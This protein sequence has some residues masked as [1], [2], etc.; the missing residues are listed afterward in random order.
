MRYLKWSFWP[1]I[2]SLFHGDVFILKS[3]AMWE[4]LVWLSL[5]NEKQTLKSASPKN[6]QDLSD[7]LSSNTIHNADLGSLIFYRTEQLV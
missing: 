2:R 7:I 5:M 4:I 3:P 6:F 1:M